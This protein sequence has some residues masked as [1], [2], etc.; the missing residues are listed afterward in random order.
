MSRLQ[1]GAF[2]ALVVATVAAFFI[3]QHLKV[4]TPLLQGSPAPVPAAFDP[5]YGFSG[6]DHLD[7]LQPLR[8][9]SNDCSVRSHH[10]RCAHRLDDWGHVR[11]HQLADCLWQLGLPAQ[12]AGVLGTRFAG[13]R[14]G[15]ELD[16]QRGWRGWKQRNRAESARRS[17]GAGADHGGPPDGATEHG[18]RPQQ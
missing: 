16:D 6:H 17:S 2:S 11:Q 14:L 13:Q 9:D 3:A 12:L 8:S 18:P 15:L 4:T 1:V 5:L 10:L 7:H